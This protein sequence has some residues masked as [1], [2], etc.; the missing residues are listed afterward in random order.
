[1]T[2][3]AKFPKLNGGMVN[4]SVLVADICGFDTGG[5][6]GGRVGEIKYKKAIALLK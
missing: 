3:R 5:E 2:H 6:C 1:M 4:T